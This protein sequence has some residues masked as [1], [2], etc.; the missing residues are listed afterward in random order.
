V[1]CEVGPQDSRRQKRESTLGIL[2]EI[3][4]LPEALNGLS[5]VLAALAKAQNEHAPAEDRLDELERSR[6]IWEAECEAELLKATSKYRAATAAEQRMRK[7]NEKADP[8][9]EEGEEITEGIPPEYAGASDA[10]GLL[11]LHP[12]LALLSPK[13][14]ALRMKFS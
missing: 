10:E 6:S 11:P 5:Y 4:R 3:S 1:V 2:R 12:D 9:D 8:F 14:L 13:Q 7:I